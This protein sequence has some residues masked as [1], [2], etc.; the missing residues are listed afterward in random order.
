[1]AKKRSRWW[2]LCVLVLF[3]GVLGLGRRFACSPF[4]S[5]DAAHA[6]IAVD[7]ALPGSRAA[8]HG[9]FASL[10]DEPDDDGAAPDGLSL[11]GRVIYPDGRAASGASVRLLS[12]P[13]GAPHASM[14]HRVARSDADG[15]FAFARQAQGDYMLEAQ[16]DDAVSPTTPARLLPGTDPVTLMVF[17]AATLAVHVLSAVDHK[18]IADATVKLGIGLGLFGASDAYVLE[19]TDEA[20]IAHFRGVA[21]IENHP[22]FAFADG[23]AGTFDNIRASAHLLSSWETTLQLQ[24]GADVSGRVTDERGIPIP[25]AKVGWEPGPGEPDGAYT[26]VTPLADGGHYIA[27]ITD[28]AGVFHKTVPPGLGCLVAVH[29]SHLTAQACGVRTTM[30]QPRTDVQIVMKS[31]ARV[32]GVVVTADGKPAP[33]AEVIVTHPSWEHIPRLSDSYRSRT[34]TDAQGRFAFDGVDHMPL[35]L[36]AWTDEA[37][38]DLVEL[39]L[40]G[41]NE[42]ANVKI[43]LANDGLI[44]GTV[45]EEDGGAAPFAVVT[46]FVAPDIDKIVWAKAEADARGLALPKSIGGALCDAAGKFRFAGLPP[47]VYALRAQRPAATSV[48]PA[49]SAVWRYKVA[50]GS[51]VTMVLPGLGAIAGHVVDED[52]K[53]VT[54]FAVSFAIWEPAMQT[55]AMPTGRPVISADGSFKIDSVPANVYAIAVSGPGI[56]EWRTPS[57]VEV[58]TSRVTDLGTIKVKVGEQISGRVLSRAGAFVANADVTMATADKPDLFLHA[59]SDADG[60]FTLPVV[61]RGTA[62]KVRASTESNTSE[63]VSVA[64]GVTTVDIV[65]ADPTRGSVRGVIIDPEHPIAERPV[66]LTLRGSGLPGEGLKPEGFTTALDSGRFALDGIPAGDYALWV[67]RA[68]GKPGEE[69]LSRPIAVQGTKETSVVID[70]SQEPPP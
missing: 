35:A 3:A 4:G 34:T 66:V 13:S 47:G 8:S 56:V 57:S 27:A 42:R 45:T 50:L 40:R 25:G 26:F 38:S 23:F 39:D 16:T 46:Y 70:L 36:T 62:V 11:V 43:V 53:P 28:A 6:P 69:W 67:R 12:R 41:V 20:G 22:V 17:P 18:P 30:G 63:W 51:D 29:P 58:K 10:S 68:K 1:M 54:D 33:R 49:Y 37:S 60:H 44:T 19:R 52:G 24:P 32:S 21:P 61:T 7:P 59:E 65:M 9:A 31:G 2:L 64:P 14:P 48:A 5:Q 55:A 15:A